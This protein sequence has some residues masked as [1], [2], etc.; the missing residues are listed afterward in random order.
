MEVAGRLL[1]QNCIAQIRDEFQDA[2]ILW[3]RVGDGSL[4]FELAPESNVVRRS[5]PRLDLRTR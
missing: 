3:I 1:G 2:G 4:D 5:T